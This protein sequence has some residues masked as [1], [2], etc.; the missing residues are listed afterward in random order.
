MSATGLESID[1]S[2]QLTH[3][4][5]NEL[6]ARLRWDNKARSYRLLRTVLQALRDWVP[7]NEAVDLAAQLPTHLRGVYYEHWRPATT[8]AKH[9]S[10]ADFVARVDHAFVQ[11][12]IRNT[13]A[14]IAVTLQFLTTK[15]SSGELE[16]IRQ[17]LPADVRV[18]WPDRSE[19]A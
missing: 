12:P 2:V 6:D 18:L 16:N 3:V 13:A 5:I 14:A 1:H 8:P 17:S 10:K 11:D 9:R 4:W 19:A 15:I 7:V